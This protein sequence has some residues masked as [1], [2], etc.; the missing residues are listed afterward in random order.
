MADYK[1]LHVNKN[2]AAVKLNAS[3][4][5]AGPFPAQCTLFTS[6]IP[7]TS[8]TVDV[9]GFNMPVILLKFTAVISLPVDVFATLN[10]EVTRT[11]SEGMPAKI[12]A[13]YD[14][15]H[16]G[17]DLQSRS[18]CFQLFDTELES[19][20]YTYAVAL[21]PNSAIACA[22]GMT[23][24]NSV[25]SALTIDKQPNDHK[26][27]GSIGNIGDIGIWDVNR[28]HMCCPIGYAVFKL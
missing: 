1:D 6:P 27:K 7:I 23:I 14:F 24:V 28:M 19:G 25:L 11:K 18:F 20:T 15:T 22:P 5:G 16:C 10:F 12:G 2:E 17:G 3:S 21:S 13:T 4:G 8:V 26:A 9:N